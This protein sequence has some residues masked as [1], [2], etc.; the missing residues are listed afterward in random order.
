[1]LRSVRMRSRRA[2]G[3]VLRLSPKSR[4]KTARGLFS[5]G[6]GVVGVRQESVVM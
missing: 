5:M 3:S 1:M 4:S 6:S 2:A